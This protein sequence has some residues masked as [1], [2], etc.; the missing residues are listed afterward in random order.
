[1][2]DVHSVSELPLH[3]IINCG[4]RL[5]VDCVTR[6]HEIQVKQKKSLSNNY[7]VL[8]LNVILTDSK[9]RLKLLTEQ[10]PNLL[11]NGLAENCLH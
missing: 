10:N 9:S 6:G 2:C 4:C 7:P 1:M 8:F 3:R 11:Q 5:C